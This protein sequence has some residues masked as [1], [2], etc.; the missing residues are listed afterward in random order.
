MSDN[1]RRLAGTIAANGPPR[2]GQP[3]DDRRGPPPTVAPQRSRSTPGW[4]AAGVPPPSTDRL[5]Q[6]SPAGDRGGWTRALHISAVAATKR[7]MAQRSSALTP[8]DWA[9][10]RAVSDPVFAS[11]DAQEGA[12]AFAEKRAPVW[13]GR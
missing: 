13:R 9:A 3:P 2:L 4:P 10:M 7:I 5:P 8:D 11:A 12:R 6:C 1:A